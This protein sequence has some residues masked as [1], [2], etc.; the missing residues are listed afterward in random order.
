MG[1]KCK[2]CG[3][4]PRCFALCEV[5]LCFSLGN[6]FSLWLDLPVCEDVYGRI[7]IATALSVTAFALAP[8]NIESLAMS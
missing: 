2:Q 1:F 8:K 4:E 5:F 6:V 7:A 3:S